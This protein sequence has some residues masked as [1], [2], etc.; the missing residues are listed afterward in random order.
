MKDFRAQES[1]VPHIVSKVYL[2]FRPPTLSRDSKCS[3]S[4]VEDVS[5]NL[6]VRVSGEYFGR[7]IKR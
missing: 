4:R 3:L 6:K 5:Q 1:R 7:T 2:Y